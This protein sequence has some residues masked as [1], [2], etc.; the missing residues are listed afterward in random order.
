ELLQNLPR[1]KLRRC[2][3]YA[4]EHPESFVLPEDL[5]E[6]TA[7]L[8][9]RAQDAADSVLSSR[10]G[11]MG[12]LDEALNAV[13]LRDETWQIARRLAELTQVTGDYAAIVGDDVPPEFAAAYRP[14]DE[15]LRTSLASL[16]AR[17]E[18]L[19]DYAEKVRRADRHLEVFHN[20]ERLREHRPRFEK[21]R[22]DLLADELSRPGGEE[23]GAEVEQVE[24]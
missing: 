1:L 12:L 7:P 5:D 21:L 6:T 19:E 9:R 10:I 4:C 11:A 22:A 13:R 8:L 2:L 17:V 14:Y 16:T 3:R 18:A 15:T 20:I 23:L 24:R